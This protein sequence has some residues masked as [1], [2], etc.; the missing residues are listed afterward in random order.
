MTSELE[1]AHLTELLCEQ[2]ACPSHTL[3]DKTICD[4]SSST[5]AQAPDATDRVN[6]IIKHRKRTENT[7]IEDRMYHP[8]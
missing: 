4:Y 1:A 5:F 6:T 8:A 2:R 3:G 7:E